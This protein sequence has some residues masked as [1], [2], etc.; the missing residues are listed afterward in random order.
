M[1]KCSLFFLFLIC[2]FFNLILTVESVEDK[3]IIILENKNISLLDACTVYENATR[4][5]IRKCYI[6]N[7]K[8]I[9]L[10]PSDS[11]SNENVNILPLPSSINIKD[12]VNLTIWKSKV[13][14]NNI[15]ENGY[16][17]VVEPSFASNGTVIFYTGNH[18]AARSEIGKEWKY[19][20]PYFDFKGKVPVGTHE[21]PKFMD[22]FWADQRAIYDPIHNI[23]I[24]LRQGEPFSQHFGQ[25]L[26]NDRLAISND[27]IKWKVYDLFP[28]RIFPKLYENSSKLIFDYPQLALS[29]KYLYLTTSLNDANK[30]YSTIFRFSLNDL[31]NFTT[32]RYDVIL[33]KNLKGVEP[34]QG[35]GP[36]NTMYFGG[37]IP[38]LKYGMKIYQ[39]NENAKTPESY[40][41]PI[42][43]WNDM[44]NSKYCGNDSKLWW[45]QSKYIDSRIR[46]AW[47][48]NNSINFL[49]NAIISYDNGK[50]WV[51]YIDVATFNLAENITYE[52][53]YYLADKK[54]GWMYGTA[55]PNKNGQLGIF[56]HYS[57]NNNTH[58]YLNLAF[59]IFNHTNNKWDITP[60]INSTHPLPTINDNRE[61]TFDWGDFLTIR[62]HSKNSTNDDF[63]WDAGG[64]VLVGN[65]SKAVDPYFIMVK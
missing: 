37:H 20:N 7:T 38:N 32:V 57:T 65:S 31:G 55:I 6:T 40:Q 1:F 51:P 29:Q 15:P 64:Y 11:I 17:Q 4:E 8:E 2:C 45:C 9:K 41:M 28:N 33:D 60:L 44:R 61:K 22:L 30:T 5:D 52:R 50:T 39:W 14:S 56:A 24:W 26:N 23:Y 49:W 10:H 46:S 13:K 58:P 18:F 3:D 19:V 34:V 53:K 21:V 35:I 12:F 16:F 43:L 62:E 36:N 25:I 63:K 59:G 27:A 48:Y 47:L 54:L 42:T